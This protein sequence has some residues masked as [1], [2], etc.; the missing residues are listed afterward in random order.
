MAKN[1]SL[2]MICIITAVL[3][4]GLF[5]FKAISDTPLINKDDFLSKGK[6]VF[7]DNNTGDSVVF[8]RDDLDTLADNINAL[9]AEAKALDAIKTELEK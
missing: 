3:L 2:K 9:D 1:V 7:V 8:S 5:V 6:I 4:S